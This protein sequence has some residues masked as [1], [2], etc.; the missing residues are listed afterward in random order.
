MSRHLNGPKRRDEQRHRREQRHLKQHGQRTGKTNARQLFERR[1]NG[2]F[3]YP[4]GHQFPQVGMP[5][6]V[7]H[8]RQEHD[9]IDD[10]R[11]DARTRPAERREAELAENQDIVARYIDEQPHKAR[12]HG[13]THKRHPLHA[14]AQSHEQQVGRS[15]PDD[16][17]QV[18]P[19]HEPE[20]P[21]NAHIGEMERYQ[22]HDKDERNRN[23]QRHPDTLPHD[24]PTPC[25]CSPLRMDPAP[26]SCATHGVTAS[27]S[28]CPNRTSG[29]QSDPAS[30]TAAISTAPTR[31]VMTISTNPIE[32]MAI[33][34]KRAGTARVS[35]VFISVR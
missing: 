26:R 23:E 33:C 11:G 15:A 3:P 24:V 13:R 16:R 2:D 4:P 22:I 20:S 25:K 32:I 29:T 17:P 8:H 21:L 14:A 28:P 6:H 35:C 5:A 12:E 31:P 10:R 27:S 1:P 30:A 7:H 34:A 18:L 9:P 19:R